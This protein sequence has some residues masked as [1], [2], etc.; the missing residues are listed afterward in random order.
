[1]LKSF[2]LAAAAALAMTPAW[3]SS[4]P[5]RP[6]IVLVVLDDVGFSDM[7]AFG[8]EIATPALDRMAKGG[9]RFTN[10][11]V[12]AACSPTRAMLMT[13]VDNHR[14]GVGTLE[15]VIADNQKGKPGYEGYLNSRVVS[16]GSLLADA[17]YRTYFAGNGTWAKPATNR[18]PRTASRSRWPWPRLAAT[19]SKANPTRRFTNRRIGSRARARCRCPRTSTQAATTSTA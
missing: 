14:A 5:T 12:A 11:H 4:A 3:G 19:T 17:G 15:N 2:V 13:G 8:G 10:F 1:L 7:G 6:N 16:I 9:V 18:P